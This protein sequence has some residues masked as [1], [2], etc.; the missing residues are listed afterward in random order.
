VGSGN[1]PAL[2]QFFKSLGDVQHKKGPVQN[3]A[4]A[5]AQSL[6]A[7]KSLTGFITGNG[8][9]DPRFGFDAIVDALFK[10]NKD[11]T[12]QNWGGWSGSAAQAFA[13]QVQ[14]VRKFGMDVAAL[15]DYTASGFTPDYSGVPPNMQ[16]E[17]ANAIPIDF[18][19]VTTSIQTILS[20]YGEIYKNA[21]KDGSGRSYPEWTR[22][23]FKIMTS[24]LRHPAASEIT[25]VNY[26]PLYTM[27]ASV[28]TFE[29]WTGNPQADLSRPQGS[30]RLNWRAYNGSGPNGSFT[31]IYQNGKTG[32]GF[33]KSY[34]LDKTE[35]WPGGTDQE[36]LPV[37]L[38]NGAMESDYYPYLNKLATEMGGL[39][40]QVKMPPSADSSKLPQ[41]QPQTSG[42]P[43]GPSTQLP[44]FGNPGSLGSSF[45][46]PGSSTL[47]VPNLESTGAVGT[48][49]PATPASFDPG[50]TGSGGNGILDPS[51][52]ASFSGGP[53]SLNGG[54]PGTGF[55]GTGGLV[56][57]GAFGS[58]SAP[59]LST[60][61]VLSGSPGAGGLAGGTANGLAGGEAGLAGAAGAA[62]VPGRGMMPPM[63]P[64][65]GMGAGQDGQGR[66]RGAYLSEDE[67]VWGASADGGTAVL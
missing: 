23:L 37:D 53:G 54:L 35:L 31:F 6:D 15:F 8:F 2:D 11:W 5:A 36:N 19:Q 12:D 66:Q 48:F 50:S 44:S 65:G 59:G 57:G 34:V 67:D 41:P 32:G 1:G 40:Q 64:M 10:K 52:L 47:P 51:Q 4:T 55:D 26:E 20:A 17:V 38:A 16:Y 63:Y 18:N 49:Q 27:T 39:Y 3:L 21:T 13:D 60:A 61:G 29:E 30:G 33:T 62:A 58:A 25:V 28:P 14:A 9:P 45:V 42:G 24:K 46:P 43:G 7:A 22:Y 56:P